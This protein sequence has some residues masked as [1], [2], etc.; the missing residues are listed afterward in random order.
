MARAAKTWD[1][2][3]KW[4]EAG[5]GGTVWDTMSFDPELNLMFIGTGN[6]RR[7]AEQAEPRAATT[8][9]SPRSSR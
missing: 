2:S 8:S 5:G 1:P 6:G 7:G 9:S 3:G 4:W